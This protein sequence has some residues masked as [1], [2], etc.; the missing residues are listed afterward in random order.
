MIQAVLNARDIRLKEQRVS[1]DA[2][3]IIERKQQELDERVAREQADIQKQS[4][5]T[6][7][8][9]QRQRALR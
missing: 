4:E 3:T 6:Q 1:K 8:L 7:S 2:L 5:R 9:L